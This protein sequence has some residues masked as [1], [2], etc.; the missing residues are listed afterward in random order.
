M[1]TVT[2]EL[3]FADQCTICHRPIDSV[4]VRDQCPHAAAKPTPEPV[5]HMI[6]LSLTVEQRHMLIFLLRRYSAQLGTDITMHSFRDA[7]ERAIH[8][9]DEAFK[10]LR[11]LTKANA[12]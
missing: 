11:V 3:N 6:N 5:N 8:E 12:G 4:C 10:L 9:H 1:I 7:Q 2:D